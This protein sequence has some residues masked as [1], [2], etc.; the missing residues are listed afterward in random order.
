MILTAEADDARSPEVLD[1]WRA[2]RAVLRPGVSPGLHNSA[3]QSVLLC[4]EPF[5][6][7][8]DQCGRRKQPE[9]FAK[10]KQNFSVAQEE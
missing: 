9:S 7:S 4:R 5:V 1:R 10:E 6:D 3:A 2:W 8:R